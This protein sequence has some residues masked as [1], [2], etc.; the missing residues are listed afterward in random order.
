MTESNEVFKGVWIPAEVWEDENLTWQQKMLWA[1]VSSLGRAS[2]PCF[3]SNDWLAQRL[4]STPGSVAAQLSK[5]REL[6][7][8]KDVKFD[9]RRR[10][11]LAVVPDNKSN[12]A[13][14]P[15]LTQTLTPVKPCNQ[16][17]L[18]HEQPLI[19]RENKGEKEGSRMATPPPLEVVAWNRCIKLPRTLAWAGQR[20]AKL[21]ARRKDEFFVAN[22]EAAIGKLCE[23]SFATGNNDRGWRAT[24]DW[25]LQPDSVARIMEGKYDNKK[26]QPIRQPGQS[27]GLTL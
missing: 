1:I 16:P 3:A 2:L 19:L 15:G 23:S 5:L 22:Y 9:G 24:F 20:M 10:E 17:G 18:N 11:I 7:Y 26:I 25:F 12:A 14:N 27:M 4:Q 6:G 21:K 13:F 8:I